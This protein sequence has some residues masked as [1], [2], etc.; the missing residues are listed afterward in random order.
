MLSRQ[1]KKLLTR[2]FYPPKYTHNYHKERELGLLKDQNIQ[3]H[4]T[5]NE[6]IF[7]DIVGANM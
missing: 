7:V 2:Y 6:V 1:E 5:W 3:A 4:V